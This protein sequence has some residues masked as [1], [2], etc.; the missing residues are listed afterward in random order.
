MSVAAGEMIV[1]C[2]GVYFGLG[3]LLAIAFVTF[4][5]SKIDPAAIGMPLK[6]RLIILPGVMLLWPLMGYKWVT[7]T[8]P[9][10]S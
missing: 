1:L 9:P 3:F 4:G 2:L 5:V 7:Q 8:E 10:V 6:A